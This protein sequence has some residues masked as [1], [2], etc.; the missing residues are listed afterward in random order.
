VEIDAVAGYT[1]TMKG[2][3]AG[4]IPD[5]H[6][7]LRSFAVD[8]ERGSVC[9]YAAF[10][11]TNTG[12]CGPGAPTVNKVESD[13]VYV[14]EFDQGRIR[15]MTKI[16]ND[17]FAMR[18]LGWGQPGNWALR[19]RS[20]CTGESSSGCAD[21][22]KPEKWMTLRLLERGRTSAKNREYC[23]RQAGSGTIRL[24]R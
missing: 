12:E 17:G 16:W 10:K 7:E 2:L 14:M 24:G 15:H 19:S 1:E 13:Y 9:G 8:E 5:G 18:Q 23:Q 21:L 22:L 3:I 6:Y 11:G 4:P 20:T